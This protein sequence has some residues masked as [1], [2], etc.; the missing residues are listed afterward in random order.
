[1][2]PSFLRG[3]AA[4][5]PRSPGRGPRRRAVALSPLLILAAAC[6]SS[7]DG[8]QAASAD[9]GPP[10]FPVTIE[11]CG[12]TV[13]VEQPP[14]RA[15]T[16]NQGATE[17][18]LALGLEDRMTGTAY[19]D[20]E[21]LPE[22]RAAYESVPVLAEEYP[23]QEVLLG[24]GPD[25]VYGSYVSAFEDEAAGDRSFLADQGIASYLSPGDCRAED[26]NV[27]IT[28]DDVF[29]EIREVGALFGVADRA[30]ALVADSRERLTHAAEGV[31]EDVS[32]FWYDSGTDAPYTAGCCGAPAMIMDA[33]GATNVFEE[34]P[35]G[36]ADGSWETAVAADPD[37]IVLVE[38]DW[39]T[40]D[41]KRDA[42]SGEPM[43]S[44]AAVRGERYVVLPFSSTTPGVRN[45][46]AVEALADGLRDLL[47]AG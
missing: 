32:I 17:I 25:F 40:V 9:D 23:S 24:A 13:T 19:L 28:F 36:W 15:V 39:D 37:V 30:E 35:G 42:L 14:E 16:M 38:A 47:G 4:L 44:M 1:M 46:A 33:A 12:E 41:A 21:V 29:T 5:R 43:A 20:D 8:T 10:G 18:M 31:P 22:H 26:G 27:P 3:G 7:G 11:N 34:L 45:V 6:G 2:I